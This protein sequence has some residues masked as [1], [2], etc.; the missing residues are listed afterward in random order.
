MESGGSTATESADAP[1]LA[2]RRSA[3]DAVLAE[4]TVGLPAVALGER[5]VA[6]DVLVARLRFAQSRIAV[7]FE[8]A[9][10]PL[11]DGFQSASS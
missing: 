9:D 8:S 1:V 4:P 10:G 5:A 2:A 7:A 6:L 11:A 3:V